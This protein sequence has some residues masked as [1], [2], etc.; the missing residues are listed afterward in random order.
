[1]TNQLELV[2]KIRK[3]Q[4]VRL[5]DVFL[6]G[7]WLI[8]LGARPG[9]GLSGIERAALVAVGAG[10]VIFNGQNYLRIE[11]EMSVIKP[12]SKT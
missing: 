1:M 9:R 8:Y 4:N 11:E 3:G 2:G 7:P 12:K 5:F 6:L 10:T